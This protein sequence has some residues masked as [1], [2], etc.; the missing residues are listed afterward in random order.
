[1]NGSSAGLSSGGGAAKTRR[2]DTFFWVNLSIG[3]IIL[4]FILLPLF[5][6]LTAPSLK[7][8][9]ETIREAEVYRSIWLSISTAVTAAAISF[10]L[11][12]IHI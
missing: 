2:P 4:I 9:A 3:S 10:V 5:E 8:I 12:L 1:M 6:M 7:A 11:S